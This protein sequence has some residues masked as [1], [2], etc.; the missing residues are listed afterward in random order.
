M[1]NVQAEANTRGATLEWLLL[2][3]A[4]SYDSSSDSGDAPPEAASDGG[5]GGE[6]KGRGK[7]KGRKK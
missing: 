1:A 7:A 6:A 4:C 2:R 5:K 3:E